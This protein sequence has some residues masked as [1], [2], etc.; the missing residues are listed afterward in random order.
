MKKTLSIIGLTL[1][2]LALMDFGVAQVLRLAEERGRLGALVQYFEYGRSVPGKLERWRANPDIPRN[3]YDVGWR[4]TIISRSEV[5]FAQEHET[6][7]PVIR[8]YSNSFVNNLLVA[9]RNVHNGLRVDTHYGPSGPPNFTFATSQYDRQNRREGDVVVFGILSFSV[10]AMAA[11]SNRTWNFESPTPMT[12]PIYRL[13][14]TG[15]KRIEP[16]IT[17]AV[18]QKALGGD[19]N[20]AAAFEA[21][22]AAEDAFYSHIVFGTTW[23]DASPFARLVRR[24]FATSHIERTNAAILAGAYPY[25][26][27]LQRMVAE[28]ART[29]R[30]DRQVPVIM[31]MQSRDPTDTDVLAIARPILERDNIPYFA[32]TEHV[33][34]M[35]LANF[36]PDGH[37]TRD[38]DAL[39]GRAFVD[40]LQEIAPNALN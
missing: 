8:A 19:P 36:R 2:I 30:A 28:F 33:D 3:F 5:T 9:A 18:D 1:F 34:P 16:L 7:G 35:N 17:G 27:V 25:K 37:Y 32:T 4:D 12:Y 14:D 26:E 11:L 13:S 31:L 15:L 22:L 10:P 6:R 24:S 29:V 21:Q 39:F 20:A 40:L 23:A 38:V